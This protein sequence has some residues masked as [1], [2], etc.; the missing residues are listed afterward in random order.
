ME[1]VLEIESPEGIDETR[2]VRVAGVEQWIWIRGS[3]RANPVLLIIHG[4]PGNPTSLIAQRFLPYER[5]YTVVHWDQ[6]GAGKTF[7]RAGDTID[8]SLTIE[9]VVQDGIAI[10]EFVK[11]YLHS[12]EIIVLGWS[13]GSLIGIE[14]ARLRPDLF[15][16]YV[17]TGQFVHKERGEQIAYAAVLEE[18]RRREDEQ[19]I[20]ELAAIGPPPYATADEQ[21]VQRDWANVFEGGGR[22]RDEYL[23]AVL[24]APRYSLGDVRSYVRG[25]FA[26]QAH[27]YG[28][29]MAGPLWKVN[30]TTQD[31]VFRLPI[32]ILQGAT[33]N[34][35]PSP[36]ARS[37]FD[38]IRAPHKEFISIEEA[39][40]MA[41]ITHA[42][43]FLQ[44]LAERVRPVA[45]SFVAPAEHSVEVHLRLSDD[46]FGS[47]GEVARLMELERE[48]EIAI[49][50]SGAGELDGNEVGQGEFVVFTYGPGADRLYSVMEPLLRESPLA[51]GGFAVKRYGELDDPDAREARV[52]LPA[53]P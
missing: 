11:G 37:F 35:T 6:P 26:S 45:D 33:D 14:M 5:A 13:W 36:L 1:H 38:A 31:P 48:L 39:G 51:Q 3:N 40:H 42:D 16:A 41:L 21:A 29:G 15:A 12:D 10:A 44:L 53:R 8:P 25:V 30:L 50:A 23:Q 2:F 4:G 28:E 47:E 46:E 9:R 52:E 43:E 24:L 27:F 19:A 49:D 17:G 7:G 20:D 32:F 22:L 34:A 18:A